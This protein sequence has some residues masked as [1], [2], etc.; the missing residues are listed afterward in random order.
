M[1][2]SAFIVNRRAVLSHARQA[3]SRVQA[4]T[5][6]VIGVIVSATAVAQDKQDFG[7]YCGALRLFSGNHPDEAIARLS[8]WSVENL[9]HVMP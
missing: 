4:F 5:A 9:R 1:A 3:T 2:S 7:G 8:A 6:V